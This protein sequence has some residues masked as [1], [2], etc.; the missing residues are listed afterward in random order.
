MLTPTDLPTVNRF[1]YKVGLHNILLELELKIEV[2]MAQTIYPLPL[3]QT[4]VKVSQ[5]CE[6]S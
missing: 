4:G 1:Y 5:M 6:V 3:S 2:L